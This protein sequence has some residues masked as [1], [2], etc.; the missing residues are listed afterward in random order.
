MNCSLGVRKQFILRDVREQLGLVRDQCSDCRMD[1]PC[2]HN[3]W[4]C[5]QLEHG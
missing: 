4:Q 1:K 5:W 2:S 3:H